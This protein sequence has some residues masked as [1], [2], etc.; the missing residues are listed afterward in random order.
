M[1]VMPKVLEQVSGKRL[2]QKVGG[3][4]TENK[5]LLQ[6]SEANQV[7]DF[8]RILNS[9]AI[10]YERSHSHVWR[11]NV[12]IHSSSAITTPRPRSSYSLRTVSQAYHYL[13]RQH[14]ESLQPLIDKY[15][16]DNTD[17]KNPPVQSNW[18]QN[19]QELS[20]FYEDDKDLRDEIEAIT[21]RIIVDEVSEGEQT[22]TRSNFNV[23]LAEL[24]GLNVNGECISPTNREEQSQ[25][26]IDKI[27]NLTEEWLEPIMNSQSD[28]R[29]RD[30]IDS[31][32]DCLSKNLNS[33]QIDCD[34]NVPSIT[35]SNCSEGHSRVDKTNNKDVVI[36][37]AVPA[38]DNADES[39][40]P[41]M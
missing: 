31:N 6:I 4:E 13:F 16:R 41:M 7:S 18:Y 34:S 40:P 32:V 25:S 8:E 22:T 20:E 2:C 27:G 24:F 12:A 30:S 33:V 35:F 28:D 38:I 26:P 17:L 1:F 23:N 11:R 9:S 37:L 21:D 39:R 19:L 29:K 36:H 5:I 3:K 15:R 10:L 14:E